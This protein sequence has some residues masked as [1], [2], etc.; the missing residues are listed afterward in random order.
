MCAKEYSPSFPKSYAKLLDSEGPSS[1][2]KLAK[3][4]AAESRQRKAIL[5][6]TTAVDIVKG[7]VKVNA[8]PEIVTANVN[9]R[10]DFSE[11]VRSTQKHVE[12]ILSKV[13][14]KNGLQF[15][16]WEG[17]DGDKDLGGRY[18]KVEMMGLPLEP[19]PRT[20]S[21]GGVWDMF[22][23]TIKYV[24]VSHQIPRIIAD[25]AVS[26]PFCPDQTV[27]S[28]SSP[29]WQTLETPIARCTT[30]SRATSSGSWAG[31][32]SMFLALYVVEPIPMLLC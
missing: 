16:A 17:K 31:H 15:S 18:V 32:R 8:L 11:S 27:P 3:M 29:P 10:I 19:A 25:D 22:A 9:F 2:P 30:T 23:G 14:E 26:E 13:A 21:S 4:M 28:V 7:G 24:H 6:T 12:K 20:P 5:G 1:Y